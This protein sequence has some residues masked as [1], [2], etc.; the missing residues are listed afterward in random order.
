MPNGKFR[1]GITGAS[2]VLGYSKEWLGRVLS[3]GGNTTQALRGLGFT[4]K[5]QEVATQT[6]SVRKPCRA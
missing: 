2:E 1:V 6:K 5:I 3:R 4:E